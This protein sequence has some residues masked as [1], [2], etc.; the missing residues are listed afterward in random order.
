MTGTTMV[1]LFSAAV[2]A[3]PGIVEPCEIVVDD[4]GGIDDEVEG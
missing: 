1:D 3:V 4:G 2:G